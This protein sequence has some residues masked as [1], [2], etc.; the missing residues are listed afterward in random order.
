MSVPR[1]P[2]IMKPGLKQLTPAEKKMVE[3]MNGENRVR[4]HNLLLLNK[5]KPSK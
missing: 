5:W 3:R 2:E 1:R 4:W